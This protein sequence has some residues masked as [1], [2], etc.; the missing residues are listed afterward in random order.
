MHEVRAWSLAIAAKFSD[1]HTHAAS[2][3]SHPSCAIAAARQSRAQGI[4]SEMIDDMA[5][6]LRS[7]SATLVPLLFVQAGQAFSRSRVL[8]ALFW[9][10]FVEHV[11]G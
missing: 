7:V 10:L 4:T 11:M 5:F 8:T 3:T 1:V 6:V 2:D 9:A